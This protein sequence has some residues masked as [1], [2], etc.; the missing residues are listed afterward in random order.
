V[1]SAKPAM[2]VSHKILHMETPS[3]RAVT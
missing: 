2:V 1:S 3:N